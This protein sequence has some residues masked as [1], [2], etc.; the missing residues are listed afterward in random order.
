MKFKRIKLLTCVSLWALCNVGMAQDV[1]IRNA[2][3]IDGN[4]GT[5]DQGTVLIRDGRIESLAAGTVAASGTTEIDAQGMTVMPGYID[6]HRH[7]MGQDAMQWLEQQGARNMQAWL[8]AGF[9]T[10]LSAGDDVPGILELQRRLH[11]GEITGPRLITS[12]RAN[13]FGTQ[14]EART[15]IQ[16]VAA[17]GVNAI[18]TVFQTTPG[19]TQAETLTAIV[20]EAKR[21]GLP[22]IVHVTNVADMILAVELGVTRLVHTPHTGTLNGTEGARLVAEAGIPVTSTL[23]VYVPWFDEDN[24]GRITPGGRPAVMTPDNLAR[25]A[26]APV[27]ARHL[28]DAGVAYG[29]GTDTRY[30]PRYS[31][32][33]ELRP[34]QLFFSPQDIVTI[35]TKNAAQ[36]VGLSDEIGTLEAGK[37]ADIVILD[38]DPLSDIAAL[39]EIELVLKSGKVVVDNR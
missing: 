15:A 2:R 37:V 16:Q 19:G 8:D 14:E 30:S 24:T 5:I 32:E 13:S 3:I 28:W 18:K 7:I 31:L 9:T 21:H 35:L 1:V 26:Q 12:G 27:N 36:G 4:G 34:L 23:S 38:G 11:D 29:Y 25:G 6:A 39:F 10:I 22:V 33:H 17:A 20:D